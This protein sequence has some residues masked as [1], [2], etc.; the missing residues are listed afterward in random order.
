[1]FWEQP[2]GK[3]APSVTKTFGASQHWPNGFKTD[4]PGSSP[5][6]APPLS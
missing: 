2:E 1:M 6:P 3:H 4:L 5:M